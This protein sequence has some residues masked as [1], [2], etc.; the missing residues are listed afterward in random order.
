[1]LFALVTNVAV[2]VW[3]VRLPHGFDPA[4]LSLIL[5]I[6]LFLVISFVGRPPALARDIDVIM[7]L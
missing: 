1:M 3:D 7:D 4:A 2:R 5:S 6:L